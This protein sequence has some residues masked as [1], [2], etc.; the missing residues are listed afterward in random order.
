MST[1]DAYDRAAR[2]IAA[3]PPASISRDQIVPV[4]MPIVSS[5]KPGDE[6]AMLGAVERVDGRQS[7]EAREL[8]VLEPPLL[9]QVGDGRREREREER[10]PDEVTD[11][12]ERQERASQAGLVFHRSDEARSQEERQSLGATNAPTTSTR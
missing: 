1:H 3:A 5:G 2:A 10:D 12:V 8:L 9:E 11:D 7:L 4:R 6:E